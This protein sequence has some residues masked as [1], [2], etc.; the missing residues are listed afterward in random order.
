[1][2]YR[3]CIGC[4][5]VCDKSELIRIVLEGGEIIVD[6]DHKR[7]GR[8]AYIHPRVGCIRKCLDAK[9]LSYRFRQKGV[10]IDYSVLKDLMLT[11]QVSA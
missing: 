11:I 5:T 2:T 10:T 9:L 4:K 6:K 7:P 8:G 1:M 3:S